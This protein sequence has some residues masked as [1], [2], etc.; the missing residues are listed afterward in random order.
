MLEKIQII[1]FAK[2]FKLENLFSSR[3]EQNAITLFLYTLLDYKS[4]NSS[5]KLSGAVTISNFKGFLNIN[6]SIYFA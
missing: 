2:F 5:C 6:M 4:I 1:D 3:F